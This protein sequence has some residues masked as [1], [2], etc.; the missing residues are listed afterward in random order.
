[1]SET[2]DPCDS[3]CERGLDNPVCG[4]D[5]ADYKNLCVAAENDV[6]VAHSGPC[7]IDEEPE[8]CVPG[9]PGGEGLVFGGTQT[10]CLDVYTDVSGQMVR[11]GVDDDGLEDLVCGCDG[12]I[13]LRCAAEAG[14]VGSPS[15]FSDQFVLNE[16]FRTDLHRYAEYDADGHFVR[17]TSAS[18]EIVEDGEPYVC[19][20][21]EDLVCG[22]NGV[23]YNNPWLAAQAG[24]TVDYNGECDPCRGDTQQVCGSDG[25]TYA[26]WCDAVDA[27]TTI[28]D[29]GA[30]VE[31]PNCSE[32][33]ID[34]VCGDDGITY[35]NACEAEVSGQDWIDGECQSCTGLPQAQWG[36][37]NAYCNAQDCET[38]PTD[39]SCTQVRNNFLKL[40]GKL[41]NGV[42]PCVDNYIAH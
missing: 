41:V 7:E 24:A 12:Q 30:C 29:I 27:G 38:H 15:S 36:L 21:S 10:V 6:A 37:C 1:V 11:G 17:I 32:Q 3:A 8:E 42:M 9:Q 35:R 34:L 4:E 23:T 26:N 18:C 22:T 19:D 5:G 14:W 31:I 40:G 39:K 33:A 25:E 28:I 2:T 20:V 13:Y 16:P